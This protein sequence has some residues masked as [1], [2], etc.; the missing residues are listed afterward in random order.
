MVASVRFECRGGIL[1]AN[2]LTG[3]Y[4]REASVFS[5][6]YIVAELNLQ[7]HLELIGKLWISQFRKTLGTL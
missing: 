5:L 7:T 4:G 1:R 2:E 3:G 6:A